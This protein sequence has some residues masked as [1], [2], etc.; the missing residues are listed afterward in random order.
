MTSRPDEL[1]P[2]R[3]TDARK[4]NWKPSVTTVMDVLG[5]PG[6]VNWKIDQHLEQAF[7]VACM[8]AN[9]VSVDPLYVGPNLEWWITRIKQRTELQMD[10][11]PS[12]GSDIHKSLEL[13]MSGRSMRYRYLV[14]FSRHVADV[15]EEHIKICQEVE[16]C[17]L[18]NCGKPDLD[19]EISF[20]FNGFGGQVDLLTIELNP[21]SVAKTPYFLIDYKTKQTADKFKP[22]KMCYDEHFMQLAAYREGLGLPHARCANIFICIETSEVDF[23]EHTEEQLQRGWSMFQHCF[24]LWKLKNNYDPS[25]EKAA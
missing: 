15:P 6:L 3:I 12:A 5:K 1:R 4:N 25:L 22:S 17:L 18:N 8:L 10:K 14:D 9:D 20:V 7:D 2:T 21:I 23:H 11:A 13:W 16:A 19:T 24:E